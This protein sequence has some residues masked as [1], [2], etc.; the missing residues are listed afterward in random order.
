MGD[1]MTFP[2]ISDVR[3]VKRPK[4]PVSRVFIHCSASDHAHHDN[5]ATMDKWHKERGWSGIGY[6]FFI[7]KDGT[8]EGGRNIESI[9]AAQKGH[10][11]GTIA[12]CVHGLDKSK[13]T[14]FQRASLRALCIHLNELYKGGLTF[15]GHKE[16]EPNK[17]CPVFDYKEWLSLDAKGRMLL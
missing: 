9:P 12:I 5:A 13:F 1:A 7:R 17:A 2:I 11:T 16:V 3:T 8:I 10:N 6:H 4:R 14:H 15:H